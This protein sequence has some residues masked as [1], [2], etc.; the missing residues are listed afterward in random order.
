LAS[1]ASAVVIVTKNRQSDLRRAVASALEQTAKPEVVVIDDGSADGTADMVRREFPQACL[2]RSGASLGYIAQRNR[3]ARLTDADVIVS[4]DDDAVFSSPGVVEQ[5]ITAFG[6]PRVAA[7][8]I[9]YIEPHKSE[10]M[11]QTAPD[12]RG[13]WATDAFRGTAHALRR[14]IFL[15]L[16][17]YREQLVHLGE[18]QDLGVRFLEQGFVVRVGY[19]EHIIH[20]EAQQRDW[21]RIEYYGRRNDILFVWHNVPAAFAPQHLLGTTMNGLRWSIAA[22]STAMARGTLA[23]YADSARRWNERAPVSVPVYRLHRQLKKQGPRLL[24]EIEHMLPAI[25]ADLRA[26]LDPVTSVRSV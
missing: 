25:A 9:P 20:F 15:K 10:Q 24:C 18:E 17:G 2:H 23:G 26:G 12:N 8:A 3:A 19:G 22:R 1:L 4:I 6:H 21:S 7:V 16:G 5:A 11:L 14:D 13:I